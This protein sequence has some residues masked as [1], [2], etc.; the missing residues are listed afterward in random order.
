M[1][2]PE[3]RLRELGIE[4]P[5]PPAPLG[6]YVEAVRSGGL[7]FF[8]GMLPVVDGQAKYLGRI[9]SELDAASGRDALYAASLN[10]LSAARDHLGTLDKVRRVI[11]L[12]I[13]LVTT[14]GFTGHPKVADA[15]S[16]LFQNVF[17]KEEGSVRIVLG[18]TSLP[19]GVPVELEV[20]LELTK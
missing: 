19:L 5:P 13:Y 3:Q 7:L 20:I 15:A 4:L 6:A 14:P 18:V 12:G 17:G 8:S 1:V 10:A 9:G 2:G 11:K 16:E